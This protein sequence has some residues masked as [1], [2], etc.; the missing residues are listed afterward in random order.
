MHKS[1]LDKA[2]LLRILG[3]TCNCESVELK[4]K[5]SDNFLREIT[6]AYRPQ[7]TELRGAVHFGNS[8]NKSASPASR[9]LKPCKELRKSRKKIHT[10]QQAPEK[11]SGPAVL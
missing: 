1:A 7:L 11:P 8:D 10:S 5:L 6:K 2:T 4:K 3:S 9:H